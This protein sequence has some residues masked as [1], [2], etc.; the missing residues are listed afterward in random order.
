ML[1]VPH[2]STVRMC[3]F[4]V[5]SYCSYPLQHIKSKKRRIYT[6]HFKKE[7][8]KT[9]Y[10]IFFFLQHFCDTHCVRTKCSH[11]HSLILE[12]RS[13][14]QLSMYSVYQFNLKKKIMSKLGSKIF[15]SPKCFNLRGS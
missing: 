6:L 12:L 2:L 7:T 15:Y 14:K 5:A 1:T 8:S 13:H 10:C 3:N 9:G 4:I 11:P